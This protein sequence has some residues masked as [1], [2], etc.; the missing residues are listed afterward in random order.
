MVHSQGFRDRGI[1][2]VNEVL[3]LIKQHQEIVS[4]QSK[5]NHMMFLWQLVNIELWQRN[6]DKNLFSE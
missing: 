1:F 2:N 6:L 4:C 5:E 3:R